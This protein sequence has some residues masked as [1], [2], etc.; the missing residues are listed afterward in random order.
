MGAETPDN[1]TDR[2]LI[3]GGSG[4]HDGREI[5]IRGRMFNDVDLIRK[6]YL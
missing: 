4:P 5:A 1:R 6:G 3:D 2:A